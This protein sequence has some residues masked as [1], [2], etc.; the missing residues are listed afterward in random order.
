MTMRTR[1]YF[2]CANGHEGIRKTMENDQP[3]SKMYY[4]ESLTGM[5]EGDKDERGWQ[6]LTCTVCGQRMEPITKP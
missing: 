1:E 3:Y 2:R 5:A 6:I 4:H